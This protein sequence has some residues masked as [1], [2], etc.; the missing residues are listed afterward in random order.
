MVGRREKEEKCFDMGASQV[1]GVFC[2]YV[3][4]VVI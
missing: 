2:V 3:I 4:F 1:G